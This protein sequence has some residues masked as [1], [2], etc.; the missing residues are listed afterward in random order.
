VLV[1]FDRLMP[2]QAAFARQSVNQCQSSTS[3]LIRQRAEDALRDQPL[4]TVDDLLK[5][6]EDA[7]NVKAS[8]LYLYRAASLAKEQKDV[9]RALKIL[10]SMTAEARDFMGGSWEAYRW[11]WGALSAL[12]H[13]RSGDI[14]G[15]RLVIN[16]APVDLQPFVLIAIVSQL[17]PTSDKGINPA[18][19][20]LDEARTSLRRSSVPD[21]EKWSWY[22]ELL[23]LT[24]KY[25]PEQANAALKDAVAALNR[26]EQAKE[27]GS[28]QDK[29]KTS[30]LDTLE[31]SRTLPASLLEMDEYAV[32]EAVSSITSPYTRTQVRLELLNVCLQ[33]LRSSKPSPPSPKPAISSG[34]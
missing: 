15:M 20:L 27:K 18:L 34:E 2:Q 11:Q 3:P 30:S 13:L 25:Q 14:Y 10:D 5:A 8:T 16:A 22:F 17:P 28:A 31:I 1:H 29:N 19:Q 26:A 4:K 6:A 24:V 12:N 21:V 33:R 23:Q 32:K 9:D 7:Q